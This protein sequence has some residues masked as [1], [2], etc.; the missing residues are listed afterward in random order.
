MSSLLLDANPLGENY[1]VLLRQSPDSDTTI[2]QL[3]NG[4]GAAKEDSHTGNAVPGAFIGWVG[5]WRSDPAPEV[6]FIFH[7]ST[8]GLGF[9]TEALKAFVVLF[10]TC[11]PQF[12]V[13]EAYC[14]TENA[15][16]IKVLRKCGF[17]LAEVTKG[18]YTLPWM[19]P[20]KRDTMQFCLVRPG[21]DNGGK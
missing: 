3:D 16:S 11:K 4:Q 10:W 6:G 2:N 1:A 14:D 15:G 19:K 17:E 18:D 13:L 9:A 20:S 8:W 12:N 21:Y 7:Q 5:T